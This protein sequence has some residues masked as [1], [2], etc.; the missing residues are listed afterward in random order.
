M[1]GARQFR[2]HD[3]FFTITA[4]IWK[5]IPLFLKKLDY[6]RKIRLFEKKPDYCTIPIIVENIRLF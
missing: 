3:N 6:C 5:K 1:R 2:L 4:I